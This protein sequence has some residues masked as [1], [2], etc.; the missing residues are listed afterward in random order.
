MRLETHSSI[1]TK[2]GLYVN[3]QYVVFITKPKDRHKRILI[4]AEQSHLPFI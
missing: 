3:T 2:S 1:I 4:H